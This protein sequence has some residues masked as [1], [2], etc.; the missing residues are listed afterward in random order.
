MEDIKDKKNSRSLA[1]TVFFTI[2]LGAIGSGFWELFLSDTVYWIWKCLVKTVSIFS[3]SI[4]DYIH[5]KIGLGIR[6]S[7]GTWNIVVFTCMGLGAGFWVASIRMIKEYNNKF[8]TV[9]LLCMAI[10]MSFTLMNYGYRTNYN[11]GAVI[12]IERSIEIL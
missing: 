4:L 5:A 9:S 1:K 3:H 8:A 11:M 7:F 12:F 10:V 6:E 2:L